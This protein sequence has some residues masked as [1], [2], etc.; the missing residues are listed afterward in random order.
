MTGTPVLSE[1]LGILR[2][3]ELLP[4]AGLQL[5]YLAGP[6]PRH[7][8]SA[9]WH[10][11]ATA[12][13]KSYGFAGMIIAPQVLGET[14]ESE[15]RQL[16]WEYEAQTRADALLFWV[17]RDHTEA[18]GLTTNLEWGIWHASGKVAIGIPPN[19]PSTLPVRYSAKRVGVP[20][21]A[22][23]DETVRAVLGLLA[24]RG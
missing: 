9:S 15:E 14:R 13:L 18:P 12:L 21:F 23:L 3:C 6:V 4:A 7:I 22:T 1:A 8:E 5:V 16:A 20:V 24:S 19:A 10:L 11:T 2:P 17:A